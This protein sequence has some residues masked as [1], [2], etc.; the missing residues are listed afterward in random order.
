MTISSTTQ[1]DEHGSGGRITFWMWLRAGFV[2][3]VVPGLALF[4]PAWTLNWLMAWLYVILSIVAFAVSRAIVARLHPDMLLER[5]KMLDHPD[6]KQ[7]DKALSPLMGLL[8]PLTIL[9]VAGFSHRLGWGADVPFWAQWTALGVCV[10]GYALGSW[11][12]ATNRFFSGVVRVQTD[13]GHT[14]VSSGPY[15][16]V[17]HPGYSSA[18]IANL[19]LPILLG[20]YWAFIPALVTVALMVVRTALEDRTLRAELPGY[21]DYT[22]RTRYRLVPGMW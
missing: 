12:M 8:A 22:H 3:G 17:R 18:A 15:A 19:T 21:E 14:V 9:I 13:R 7:W 4:L 16:I 5:G 1:S 11:A 2:V 20:A 10:L 6:A